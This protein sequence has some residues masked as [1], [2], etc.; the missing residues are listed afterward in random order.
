MSKEK[1]ERLNGGAGKNKK[2]LKKERLRKILALELF[3]GR[4]N[5]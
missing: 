5:L 4:N 3:A 1:M 2:S